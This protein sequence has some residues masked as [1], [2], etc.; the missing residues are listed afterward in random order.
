MNNKLR[1]I[2][3]GILIILISSFIYLSL[4]TGENNNKD[5]TPPVIHSLTG[6]T[7]G[8]PGKI[9]R[10]NAN[11]SDNIK[12]TDANIFFK[13]R[14]SGNWKSASI[15]N[16]S[17]DIELPGNAEEDWHYYIMVNDKAGN[18][19]VRKPMKQN[20]TITVKEIKK[21]IIHNVFIEEGTYT[22]CQYCPPIEKDLYEIYNSK[23]YNLNYV[24]LV[25]DKNE[26]A[27]N[28]L[29]NHYNIYGF[30]SLY[31]D[32]GYEI[33]V[34]GS[35]SKETIEEKIQNAEKR[36][37]PEIYLNVTAKVEKEQNEVQVFAELI[38]YEN[39]A[40]NGN[41]KLYLVQKISTS[42]F[43]SEGNAY[44]NYF[45]DYL[46]D[47][48]IEIPAD[49][50]KNISVN[51]DASEY[52]IENLKIIGVLFDSSSTEKHSN[53]GNEG[54]PFDAYYADASD[55]ADIVEKANLP[56]SLGIS[57]P[58]SGKFHLFGKDLFNTPNRRTVQLGRTTIEIE[59]SDDSGL[60]KVELYLNDEL[61]K[62][63]TEK[64]Y[65][66]RW[67]KPTWTQLT[68]RY[69]IKAI[70]YDDQGKSSTATTDVS[71]FILL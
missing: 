38:N 66:W 11:F 3:L 36:T 51:Y 46:Y 40:Y 50:E 53:P 58:K 49:G 21:E 5:A 55:D 8:S 15:I 1:F 24:T 39:S 42:A 45:I 27:E 60:E 10:I 71:A 34:G 2:L 43:N 35:T 32:G 54:N 12:V 70:A 41:F 13:Q 18:G 33:I 31:I 19:P 37:I 44:H 67:K 23:E 56:P 4:S 65:E 59:A 16:E 29:N 17:Y 25:R 28:R 6:N 69:T 14:N 62:E 61:V 57:H 9:V 63:F 68:F 64:P 20:Y 30:P 52:D 47:K 26:E 7:T 22:S 48:N